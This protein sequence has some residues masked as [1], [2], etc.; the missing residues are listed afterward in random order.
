MRLLQT[1]TQRYPSLESRQFRHYCLAQI[2]SLTGTWMQAVSIPWIAYKLTG[3][4]E[5]IGIVGA[6][7]AL[8][9]TLMALFA[10]AAL[11]NLPKR[12]VV[13]ATQLSLALIAVLLAMSV[14]F[15]LLTFPLLVCMAAAVGICNAVD[16]TARSTL[17]SELVDTKSVGNA[18]S[19]GF[20]IF[21]FSRVLGPVLAGIAISSIG[22]GWT[23]MVNALSSIPLLLW[24]AHT[25]RS[26]TSSPPGAHRKMLVGVTAGIAY[27][28]ARPELW[29][30]LATV[31]CMG[32]FGFNFSVL[33]PPLLSTR[34]GLDEA[35]YGVM[36]SC[37]GLGGFAGALVAA[38]EYS[39][40]RGSALLIALPCTTAVLLLM[41]AIG[42]SLAALMIAMGLLG[43]ANIMF[44]S[45]ANARLQAACDPE[46]RGRVIGMYVLCFGGMTPVGNT[47]AGVLSERVG[48]D[49]AFSVMAASLLVCVVTI[50]AVSAVF[51]G[52][53][54]QTA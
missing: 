37:L 13:F 53:T 32:I 49:V 54:G 8:P 10:G 21:N 16:Q 51:D 20:I 42:S 31:C 6:A 11:D 18:A 7:Q 30:N 22:I 47:I 45:I 35:A 3:S 17:V 15:D 24:L 12:K 23:L 34:F 43:I 14:A 38:S 9:I 4:A 1:L 28:R 39:V 41:L 26:N 46:F 33:L 40:A 5:K 2:V 29:K 52:R 19:L 48:P 44:F 36:L 27:V 25:L 50:R